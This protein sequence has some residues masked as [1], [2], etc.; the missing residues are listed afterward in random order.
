MG[1][2]QK[3]EEKELVIPE[4]IPKERSAMSSYLNKGFRNTGPK[5]I[6]VLQF[7]KPLQP[8]ATECK[9]TV[10]TKNV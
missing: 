5:T 10:L 4:A 1:P 3:C 2:E 9:K 8:R 7:G 6:S